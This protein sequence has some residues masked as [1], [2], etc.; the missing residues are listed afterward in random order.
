[1]GYCIQPIEAT[2]SVRKRGGQCVDV[3][4]KDYGVLFLHKHEWTQSV[5]TVKTAISLGSGWYYRTLIDAFMCQCGV[6]GVVG[7]F[8]EKAACLK[9]SIVRL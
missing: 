9:G 3:S 5:G 4:Q 2:L 7:T 8:A 1:V 6:C